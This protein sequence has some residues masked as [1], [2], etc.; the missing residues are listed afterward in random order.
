MWILV[1]FM[2][3]N[4]TLEHYELGQFRTSEACQKALDDAKVLVTSNTIAVYCFEVKLNQKE[5]K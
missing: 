3:T 4:G 1:W 2:F 5:S